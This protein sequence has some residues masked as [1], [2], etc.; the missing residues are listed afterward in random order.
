[1]ILKEI[2]IR[3]DLFKNKSY[4]YFIISGF[5][6]TIGNGLIYITTSYYAFKYFNGLHGV[7]ILMLLT[8]G[9]SIIFAP[10]FGLCADKYNRK[11][12]LVFSNILR[13]I[14]VCLFVILNYLELTHNVLLL[15]LFLGIFLS[16]YMPAAIPLITSIVPKKLLI[17]ANTTIDMVYEIGT[18]LGMGLSGVL[19]HFLGI[20]KVLFLGGVIF[21]IAGLFNA[22]MKYS[23]KKIIS[24]NNYIK[25]SLDSLWYLK[26]R[27]EV[28]YIYIVQSLIMVNVMIIPILLLPYIKQF[29]NYS[30]SVFAVFEMLYSLGL[31]I[32][33]FFASILC[34]KY[35]FK[36]TASILLSLL[37]INIVILLLNIN[38]IFDM[39]SYLLI[40]FSLSVW[41]LSIAES[42]CLT[43]LKFQGRIQALFSGISGSLI[44]IF[45]L[46]IAFFETNI[47]IE[48]LYLLLVLLSILSSVLIFKKNI[49]NTKEQI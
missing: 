24:N 45:Y 21:I 8:W 12:I 25:D 37:S 17:E 28:I 43:D 44:L 47:K 42:Q 33:C 35:G 31:F 49:S 3:K 40:G 1:M 14:I 6:A 7:A 41:S 34:K 5:F 48:Y 23:H 13:G 26:K 20:A 2:C 4:L 19:I 30:V 29:L 15:N 46:I 11:F 39:I 16:F 38:I 10:F 22:I 32:G 18:V 36:S 27:K 9:P